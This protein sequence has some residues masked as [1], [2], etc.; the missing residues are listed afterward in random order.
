MLKFFLFRFGKHKEPVKPANEKVAPAPVEERPPPLQLLSLDLPSPTLTTNGLT[1]QPLVQSASEKS[2]WVDV[3]EP[4]PFDEAAEAYGQQPARLTVSEVLSLVKPCVQEIKTRGG[5]VSTRGRKCLCGIGLQTLGIFKPYRTVESPQRINKI[6]S[7]YLKSFQTEL[8]TSPSA[9]R[10]LSEELFDFDAP[11]PALAF[12]EELA[13]AAGV[14]DV[15]F[16]LKWALRHLYTALEPIDKEAAWMSPLLTLDTSIKL[17]GAYFFSNVLALLKTDSQ[18]LLLLILDL[19][20]SVATYSEF[21]GM[22]STHLCKVLGFWLLSSERNATAAYSQTGYDGISKDWHDTSIIL[23]NIFLAYLQGQKELTTR[24]RE[25]R[26]KKREPE[27][28]DQNALLVKLETKGWKPSPPGFDGKAKELA[29]RRTIGDL[30]DLT[31]TSTVSGEAKQD[32]ASWQIWKTISDHVTGTSSLRG[33]FKVALSDE[34]ARLISML[35][36]ATPSSPSIDYSPSRRRSFSVDSPVLPT[37]P[38]Q[39]VIGHLAA[40]SEDGERRGMARS[41]SSGVAN[42]PNKSFTNLPTSMPRSQSAYIPNSA[43]PSPS[44]T[45]FISKGFEENSID[46]S[47]LKLDSAFTPSP[48]VEKPHKLKR[49]H[50]RDR[51]RRELQSSSASVQSHQTDLTVNTAPPQPTHSVVI[52]KLA[53]VDE[54]WADVWV[55]AMG[56]P[57]IR[58]KWPTFAVAQLQKH[59]EVAKW[60][61]VEEVYAQDALPVMEPASPARSNTGS[62]SARCACLDFCL[63]S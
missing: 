9:A 6:I 58:S 59:S 42:F 33:P 45:D 2:L 61:V 30:Y 63:S 34:S 51:R 48:Q 24:L 35:S 8:A 36:P 52:L 39:E 10:P 40:L 16:V 13:S 18:E 17:P 4:L 47:N 54:T 27:Q 15:V 32:D 31:F 50:S 1:T 37:R 49:S 43:G 11:D 12:K 19:I 29:R 53:H 5:L 22:S 38:S 7:L 21:N 20:A 62:D 26:R 28:I 3:S 44:W 56:D 41:L 46:K 60:M 57:S 23:E 55:D 14:H 25:V